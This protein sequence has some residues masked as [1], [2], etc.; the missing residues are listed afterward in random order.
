[1]TARRRIQLRVALPAFFT[2]FVALTGIAIFSINFY[3]SIQSLNRVS[4][5][6]LTQTSQIVLE[7]T[8]QQLSPA[9][10]F[11]ELNGRLLDP[12]NFE[13]E[14][15]D[16]FNAV[17]VPQFEAYDQFALIYF[18][19]EDGNFWLNGIEP[20]Q[21]VQS[22]VIE[23]R[24]DGAESDEFLRGATEWP[25]DTPQQQAQLASQIAPYI[26]TTIYKRDA[27]GRIV[28]SEPDIDYI[29]DPRWR[30]WY[31]NAVRT[32]ATSWS[33]VYT[34]G[35]SGQFDVSNKLGV[36]VSS[37][38]RDREGELV[39]VVGVDIVLEEINTFL[40]ELVIGQNGRAFLFTDDGRGVAYGALRIPEGE[41]EPAVGDAITE[42]ADPAARAAYSQLAQ[43][44]SDPGALQNVEQLRFDLNRSRYLAA[45]APLTD[46]Q[47]PSWNVGIVIPQD[48]FIGDLRSSYLI[49]SLVSLATLVLV[50]AASL[51]ISNT[52]T[53]PLRLLTTEADRIRDLELGAE[54]ALPA[55]LFLEI[56]NMTDAFARMKSG[57]RSFTKYIP[58][59]VVSYLIRSGQDAVLGGRT[60]DLTIFF[61]DVADFTT[62]SEQMEP[63]QLVTHLGDYLGAFSQIILDSG[64]TVDK[65]IGDAVMAF[66][67]APTRVD[68]HAIAACSAALA[69]RKR[70][71]QLRQKWAGAE[72][73]LLRARIGLHVGDVI[74][75]NMGSDNRL[76]YTVL[77]DPVNLASRLEGL[78]KVYGVSILVSED[79]YQ[80]ASEA[81]MFRR[82]DRVTVKGKTVPVTVYE[83]ID[84]VRL[85]NATYL[86]WLDTYHGALDAYFAQDWD[87][88]EQQMHATVA[89]RPKDGAATLMLERIAAYRRQAP[90][91]NWDGV[92]RF[93]QK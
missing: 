88:A 52:I 1:M 73:P 43:A 35:S 83:L 28:G 14:Y 82:L 87:L 27:S 32:D 22:Q 89:L 51:Y 3:F 74:V 29:Y 12:A 57:I 91:A 13:Q 93:T 68:N 63:N 76:N 47:V 21:T 92:A 39:G 64:G 38:V 81:F 69:C 58:S 70:L 10:R 19:A 15:F 37:P 5:D 84:T 78:A 71:G 25:T 41:T 31:A 59:G 79:V 11:A 34:F 20:N 62:I 6:Y 80:R 16:A 75:G 33:S 4:F 2:L 54:A 9:A 36:T 55:S 44:V 66:W 40:R 24:I 18:G 56:Q 8:I 48:D 61:S 90:G 67:N 85:Q 86:R 72:L 7:K 45:F 53:S 50:I 30:P 49:T 42:I 17:T 26:R 60:Q 65:Y 77:G 23:R 46:P